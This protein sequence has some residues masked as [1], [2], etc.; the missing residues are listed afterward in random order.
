MEG[1]SSWQFLKYD[2]KCAVLNR[3]EQIKM[4]W[5]AY[6]VKKFKADVTFHLQRQYHS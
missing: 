4:K 6:R 3:M 5:S 2:V 1:N